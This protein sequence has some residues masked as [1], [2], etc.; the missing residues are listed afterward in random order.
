MS[1]Y[2]NDPRLRRLP[3]GSVLVSD[4]HVDVEAVVEEIDDDVWA[5][6]NTSGGAADAPYGGFDTVVNAL[7][8]DP[9]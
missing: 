2:A 4:P 3:D 1:V 9:R 7:I 5:A 6:F 8:G